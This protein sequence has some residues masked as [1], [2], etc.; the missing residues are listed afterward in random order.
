M[1]QFTPRFQPPSS[2]SSG[3]NLDIKLRTS[4]ENDDK[5]HFNSPYTKRHHES[6]KIKNLSFWGN[7]DQEMTQEEEWSERQLPI[8]FIL[9]MIILVVASTF[10]WFLFRWASGENSSIPPLIPADTAPF[11]VRPEN[12]GGMMIP[13]QDKLIYGRLS[14]GSPQPIER[15]L[16]PPEQPI[17]QTPPM[18]PSMV[19]PPQNTYP[20][21]QGYAT[22]QQQY[23]YPSPA[24]LPMVQPQPYNPAY[25]PPIPHQGAYPQQQPPLN[26]QPLY[27][28]PQ[29][30]PLYGPHMPP[31][32]VM[33]PPPLPTLSGQPPSPIDTLKP[34]TVE[35]IK[36]ATEAEEGDD[37]PSPEGIKDLD[38]LIAK[39]AEK[40]LKPRIKKSEK[41]FK[42]TALDSAK[43][44]VQ[45]ASLPTRAMAIR[46]M[47]RL[48]TQYG[49]FFANKTWGIQ[50]VNRGTNRDPTY[51]L[52]VGSFANQN[53]ALKFCKKLKSEKIGCMA[54]ASPSE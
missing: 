12:P 10:L 28:T 7:T 47:K 34:S 1:S 19:A 45:I 22:P 49:S 20:Q 32:P 18:P 14:Q 5:S 51:R 13:H 23:G 29:G 53:A 27:P 17:V 11:K 54:V 37:T 40:P 43:P 41:P 16:P 26:N 42:S 24:P 25:A 39:E 31:A 3:K 9:T 46:E 8:P 4:S 6:Q 52:M 2:R 36:P 21:Q 38:Q 33:A 50:K 30:Q 48:R 35:S 44:R 15:L